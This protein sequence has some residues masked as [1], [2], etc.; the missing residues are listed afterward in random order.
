MIA[1]ADDADY[2]SYLHLGLRCLECGEEVHLKRGDK[3][4][5]HFAHFKA[6]SDS[7]CSLRVTGYSEGWSSLS[8]EGRKQRRK[9][10]QQYFMNM[11]VR[12]DERFYQKIKTIKKKIE[13][14]KLNIL[15]EACCNHFSA[16]SS[17]LIIEC[18]K[19][20]PKN[21]NNNLLLQILITCEAIDYL[22]VPSSRRL[23]EQLVHYS[24]YKCCILTADNWNIYENQ[25]KP[26]EI[27]KKIKDILL[28]TAWLSIFSYQ[29]KKCID[30][31]TTKLPR[32]K[33][34]DEKDTE[35]KELTRLIQNY[36]YTGGE[37]STP[38]S[39]E[40]LRVKLHLQG[41]S[42]HLLDSRTSGYRKVATLG[43]LTSCHPEDVSQRA[44]IDW[45]FLDQDSISAKRI[46]NN[47]IN[48]CQK[49][50]IHI[51]NFLKTKVKINKSVNFNLIKNTRIMQED[52][53]E[54]LQK[55]LNK[56]SNIPPDKMI[57]CPHCNN[58]IRKVKFRKH[59]TK[60]HKKLF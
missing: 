46:R 21:Y 2:L 13:H 32:I 30:D 12:S 45:A 27:S 58:R 48:S 23:L 6:T 36:I 55:E 10:F 20:E 19:F 50:Q 35:A 16:N 18:R 57:S 60:A 37:P 25:I 7:Q 14:Q 15:T 3:K 40:E 31:I 59:L 24:L 39:L 42:I 44:I 29:G 52:L 49:L 56:F 41:L 47:Y 9:L 4:R 17:S 5:T 38:F 28:N 8:P 34:N 53:E 51:E 11:L 54:K 1:G 26:L 43:H 22:S 33:P